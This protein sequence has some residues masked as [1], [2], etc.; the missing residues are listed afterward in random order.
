MRFSTRIGNYTLSQWDFAYDNVKSDGSLEYFQTTTVKAEF[1]NLI[2][3]ETIELDIPL[4]E[5][6]TIVPTLISFEI[7]AN[8]CDLFTYLWKYLQQNGIIIENTIRLRPHISDTFDSNGDPI[9][10]SKRVKYYLQSEIGDENVIIGIMPKKHII[11]DITQI[12]WLNT[13]FLST[14][15]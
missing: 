9:D 13:H 5:I 14:E 7:Q 8:S 10:F 3:K 6:H 15:I 2:S 4:C 11:T 12:E 1:C